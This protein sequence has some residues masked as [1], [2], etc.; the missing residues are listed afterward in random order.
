MHIGG[1]RAQA[2]DQ[3]SHPTGLRLR[4]WRG[5]G[6]PIRRVWQLCRMHG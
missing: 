4:A 6:S 1:S 5:A 3:R 2:A